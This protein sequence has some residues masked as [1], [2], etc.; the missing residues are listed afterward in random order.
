VGK[1]FIRKLLRYAE[2]SHKGTIV[3]DK[4][5]GEHGN[6]PDALKEHDKYC[7]LLKSHIGLNPFYE[8]WVTFVRVK[9]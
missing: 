6:T 4:A 1:E 3:W 9:T 8:T 5:C 7:S 2:P